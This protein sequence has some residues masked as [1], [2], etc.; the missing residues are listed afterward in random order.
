VLSELEVRQIPVLMLITM[1][2]SGCSGSDSA[3]DKKLQ[4]IAHHV[5]SIA[6]EAHLFVQF[7]SEGH[8]TPHFTGKHPDYIRQTLDD[9]RKELR[10]AAGQSHHIG[11]IQSLN[12]LLDRLQS[13]V[14]ELQHGASGKSDWSRLEKSFTDIADSAKALA[15]I[16]EDAP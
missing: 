16:N 11:T 10:A 7:V 13:G 5:H 15:K 6:G 3:E 8:S 12:Q 9:T 1:V 2:L 4:S 14:E